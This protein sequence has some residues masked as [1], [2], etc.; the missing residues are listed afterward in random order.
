MLRKMR[1]EEGGVAQLG[2]AEEAHAGEQQRRGEDGAGEDD[3]HDAA[4]VDLERKMGGLAAHH[5]ASDDAL[6]VLHGDAALGALDEDDEGDDGDHADDEDDA[7]RW[8]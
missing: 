5:L 4:G 1:A 6:G 8:G 7:W 3:R 2:A